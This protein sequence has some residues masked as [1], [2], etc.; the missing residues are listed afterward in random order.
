MGRPH[1]LLLETLL[2]ELVSICLIDAKV[3]ACRV[4]IV[5]PDIFNAAAAAGVEVYRVRAPG[6]AVTTD[7]FGTRISMAETGA[8]IR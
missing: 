6:G 1:T 5:Q 2:E 8:Q 3:E 4:S 7:G